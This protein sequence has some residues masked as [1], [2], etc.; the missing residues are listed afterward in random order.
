MVNLEGFKG[1][2]DKVHRMAL[3]K[4]LFKSSAV[5]KNVIVD[6]AV[7]GLNRMKITTSTPQATND[8][9]SLEILKQ[10][11]ITAYIPNFRVQC[12]GVIRDVDVELEDNEILTEL[13]PPF[14][15]NSVRRLTR[16]KYIN[17]LIVQKLPV[18]F[19]DFESQTLPHYVT[20]YDARCKVAPYIC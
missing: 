7:T 13:V 12:T 9:L 11:D 19:V 5:H 1:N 16:K 18:C 8:L 3:G 14:A 2:L 17:K 20:L 15:P 4:W 6:I 10:R